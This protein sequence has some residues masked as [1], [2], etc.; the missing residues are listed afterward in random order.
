M[1]YAISIVALIALFTIATATPIN[2]GVLAFGAAFLVGG[3]LSGIPL[4]DIV[5][6]FP[7]NIFIIIV[8]ITLLFGIARTNGTIDLVVSSLLGLVRGRRWAIVWLMFVL[9]AVLMSLGSVLA[10]GML[11]PIAMPIARKYKIDPLLMGM[12]ISHGVLGAAFS[13]I[14][15]YGA[16]ING[17]LTEAGLPTNTLALYLIPLGL[18]F[19]IAL[20]L[21]LLRGRDLLRGD[22]TVVEPVDTTSGPTPDTAG[23]SAGERPLPGGAAASIATSTAPVRAA[24]AEGERPG[25]TPLRVVTLAG[26]IGLLVSAAVFGI[27]VG[28]SSLCIAAVLLLIA[29][30]RHKAAMNN[31]TWSAVILV[32]GMLT[33]MEV[34]ES[35]GTLEFLGQAAAGL[36]SPLL[37][38][39]VLCLAVAAVSAIGSS[40]GTL[41]I[42]LP[43]AAPMLATGELG[44]IGFVAALAFC[45]VVV[46]VS[47]FSSNGVMVLANAQVDDREAFQRLREVARSGS[48]RVVDVAQ[49]VLDGHSLLPKQPS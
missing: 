10:V 44:V 18:N 47:P 9:G 25:L 20:G 7:A 22:D 33:Y 24:D 11:A 17:W 5:D 36:G 38:A 43:L 31:I 12:M 15:V 40:I 28:I 30:R 29:P 48:R 14:T 1:T 4:D 49:A 41:G 42:V 34:L 37:T 26:M 19:L 35:N 8:G 45:T 3:L 32:C 39:F 2:M 21:F 16:F 13:P 27:D 23:M 6:F 46:D